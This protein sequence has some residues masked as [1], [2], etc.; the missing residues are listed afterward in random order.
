MPNTNQIIKFS[1]HLFASLFL[2]YSAIFIKELHIIFKI[3]FIIL[4]LI[5]LYDAWWFYNNDG[6]API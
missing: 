3:I 2:L 5:H 6:F 1:Y 4:G